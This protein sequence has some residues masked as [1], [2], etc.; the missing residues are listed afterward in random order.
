MGEACELFA[1]NLTPYTE[2]GRTLFDWPGDVTAGGAS[3]PLRLM[4]CLHRLVI[5]GESPELAAIYPPNEIPAHGWQ[6]FAQALVDHQDTILHQLQHA[7]QTNE[8]RRSGILLPGFMKIA[9]HV[10]HLPMVMSELGASAGLNLHWDRFSYAYGDIKWGDLLSPI[11]L[12]PKWE[13]T[14]I[15]FHDLKVVERAGC[16]LNPIDLQDEKT[17]ETLL[18]YLWADQPERLNRTRAAIDIFNEKGLK[19]DKAGAIDWLKNRLTNSYENQ[20]HIIYH[21]IARQYFSNDDKAQSKALIESA[22]ARAT[23]SS[24]LA[25]LRFEADGQKPGAALTLRVWNGSPDDGKI[26]FLARADYHGR[27]INWAK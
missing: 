19:I 6:V 10:G 16:D 22:G 11:Q 2:V 17:A 25:W 3:L 12:G 7:P 21:T 24:P 4:G 18:S 14:P 5:S 1:E 23:R 20:V 9:E 13:G 15:Q 8:V 26:Q 27:W